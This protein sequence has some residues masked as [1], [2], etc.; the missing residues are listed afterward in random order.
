MGPGD[1]AGG[2]GIF[3]LG[4]SPGTSRDTFVLD[5]CDLHVHTKASDGALSPRDIVRAAA[6]KRLAAVGICDHDT[7]SG[8]SSLFAI[9]PDTYVPLVLDGVEVVP[10]VE[11]NSQW[12]EREIHILGYYVDT[13]PGPFHDLLD[14]MQEERQTRA[15]R[16]VER[17][18]GLGLPLDLGRVAEISAGDSVGRPHVAQAMVEKGYVNS[19]KEAFDRYLGVG[20][21]AYVERFHLDPREAVRAVRKA[22]GVPVWAHPGT[23]RAM[24]LARDLVAAGLL[25]IE[26]YHPDHDKYT[27]QRC[28][29][30]AQ[31]F[32]LVVT[33]GSDFHGPS[34]GEGGDLGSVVV[35]YHVVATLRSLASPRVQ[36]P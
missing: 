31:D 9:G 20:R 32:S 2:R 19:V 25:G 23:S 12:K 5:G 11:L 10:G 17:L 29:D 35:P 26:A 14:T 7:A 27:E 36:S 21:P 13:G 6:E 8:V 4:N 22:G 28:R 16:I 15:A 18:S 30:I 24:G 3:G 1:R 33:G 34:A